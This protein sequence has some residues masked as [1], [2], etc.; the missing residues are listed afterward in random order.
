MAAALTQLGWAVS[1]PWSELGKHVVS[2]TLHG[3]HVS[4]SPISIEAISQVRQPQSTSAAVC[5]SLCMCWRSQ[6]WSLRNGPYI[7]L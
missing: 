3:G 1:V 5:C 2:V 7:T 4:G 6:K